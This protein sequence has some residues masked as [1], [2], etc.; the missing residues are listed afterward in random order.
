MVSNHSVAGKPVP[1]PLLLLVSLLWAFSPGL[2]KGRLVGIVD[3]QDLPKFK[4]M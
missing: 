4:I 2:I 3:I 1:M